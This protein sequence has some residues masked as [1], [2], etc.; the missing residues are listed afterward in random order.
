MRLVPVDYDPFAETAPEKTAPAPAPANV[1]L[2]PVD[3]DPFSPEFEMSRGESAVN[4]LMQGATHTLASV[5]KAVGE[6]AVALANLFGDNPVLGNPEGEVPEDTWT[7]QLGEQLSQWAKDNFPT[8]PNFADDFWTTK[9]PEGV[10]STVAFAAGGLAGKAAKVPVLATSGGM[11]AAAEGV[12]GVE[13]YKQHQLKEGK[14]VDPTERAKVFSASLP[15]GMT[16]AVPI[17]RALDRLDKV[18]GG[19]VKKIAAEGLKGGVEELAQ[20]VVQRIGGNLVAGK[21]VAYDPERGVF[22]GT[23]EAGEVGFTVG[24]LLNTLTAS[25]GLRR[26][27]AATQQTERMSEVVTLKPVEGDPFAQDQNTAQSPVDMPATL[28]KGHE[29]KPVVAQPEKGL[30]ESQPYDVVVPALPVSN[31]SGADIHRIEPVQKTPETENAVVKRGED[32][33]DEMKKAAMFSKPKPVAAAADAWTTLSQGEAAFQQPRSEAKELREITAEIDPGIKVENLNVPMNKRASQARE[34]KLTMPDG[35]AAYLRENRDGTLELNAALLK[36]GQSRGTALY[37]AVATFAHNNG[38]VFMGD[39]EGLS[40][41]A[42]YRRTEHMLSSALKFGTTRHLLPHPSQKVDWIKGDDKGNL[43][44]LIQKHYANITEQ[45]PLIKDIVYDFG[46]KVFLLKDSEGRGADQVVTESDF[47]QLSDSAGARA[48]KAGPA[49]LKR[50]ALTNTFLQ[51]QSPE[52]RRQVLAELARQLHS[53]L[54]PDLKNILY[55]K[56]PRDAGLSTSEAPETYKAPASVKK[57]LPVEG[58]KRL[59]AQVQLKWSDNAPR[60]EVVQS[61]DDVPPHLTDGDPHNE[62]VIDLSDFTIYLVA[63]NLASPQRVMEVLAHEAVGHASMEQM[64]GDQFEAV[65]N[66]VH[67]LKDAGQKQVS[68][69]A[70]EVAERYGKLGREAEAKE[71]IAVMAEQGIKHPVID[72]VITAIKNFL[73]KLGI[74]LK[75]SERELRALVAKAEARLKT[76]G[77]TATRKTD[78][79]TGKGMFSKPVEETLQNIDEVVAEQPA[80]KEI[81]DSVA[82]KF[83]DARPTWLGALTRLQLAD[84]GGDVLPQMN[85]YVKRAQQMDAE[86]NHLIVEAADIAKPWAEWSRANKGQAMGLSELMHEATLAGVD[87]SVPYEPLI[88]KQDAQA[89]IKT[90]SQRARLSSGEGGKYV[91]LANEVRQR[92]A[93]EQ[94]RVVA[95]PELKKKWDALPK[96]AKAI[97]E[98]VRDLYQQRF[99]Q[100]EQALLDRIDRAELSQS[101]KRKMKDEIRLRFESARVNAPYFPLARFGDFWVSVKKDGNWQKDFVVRKTGD[102]F[103]VFRKNGRTALATFAKRETAIEYA[104]EQV[105]ESEFY[106]FEGSH[107]QKAFAEQKRKQGFAITT[108]KKLENIKAV[109][110]AGAGFVSDVIG[111]LDQVPG[112]QSDMVKDAVYQLYLS[113]LPELSVRKHFIHRKKTEGYNE[114]AMRAFADQTFHGAYQLAKLQHADVLEAMLENMREQVKDSS[115]ANKASDILNELQKRHEWAMNPQGHPAANIATQGAFIWYLGLT[116]SAAL[117]NTSQTALVAAPVMAA[118]YGWGKTSKALTTAARDFFS[119]RVGF[120]DGLFSAEK[121]ANITADEKRAFAQWIDEGVIDKTLAHDLAQQ[122]EKPSEIYSGKWSKVMNVIS[123]GFHHAER[124][125]REVTAL[126]AY[127][128][129]RNNNM[130]HAQAVDEARRITYESHFDYSSA[131]KAR[132]MQNDAAKVVLIFRQYSLNMTYLLARNL[133]QGVKGES[134]E[135]RQ[136][137]RRKLAGVLGMHA[138]AAGV[139]GLPMFWLVEFILNSIFD[140]ENEPWDFRTEFRNFLADY[141]GDKGAEAI[142]VGPVQALT[143]V[144]LHNRVSL[145]ELWIRSPGRDLEMQQSIE[146]YMLQLGFGPLGSIFTGMGRG[147]DLMQRGEVGRGIEAMTPKAIRDGLKMMRYASEGVQNLRGDQVVDDLNA[148][149]LFLQGIGFTPANVAKQYDANRALKNYQNRINDRRQLLMNRWWLALQAGDADGVADALDDIRNFNGKN[150]TRRI[151]FKTLKRSALTRRKRNGQNDH[152]VYLPKRDRHLQGRVRFGDE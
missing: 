93:Q 97:Y 92:L 62:A 45:V 137:A 49:T 73:R 7:F 139:T 48:A 18:T 36:S 74:N 138:M 27:R 121:S 95:Y 110:G 118:E 108:G 15:V 103:G 68:Q 25:I 125:N 144:G 69:I 85:T 37:N 43:E 38:K 72:R 12:G 77:K 31:E 99:D 59:V 6:G 3:Y 21:V 84:V 122:S 133:Q 94:N 146:Y 55:S 54:D 109:H 60:I 63:D 70:N 151:D 134:A 24:A 75:Y 116:P 81:K 100:T 117:V 126:A 140:D 66:R 148:W 46:E 47:Q 96:E 19:G 129:A 130:S 143:G 131:N 141:F 16:E 8:N 2:E 34:W 120:K 9:V 82:D 10:G 107:Q 1:R 52:G 89:Q 98:Q 147:M 13:E 39:R 86:R 115:D 83:D 136:M 119:G 105:Q 71:I 67:Q 58:V 102:E 41:E 76:G 145:N 20:E 91:E 142:T 11:G 4:S 80:W 14:P 64:L 44:R 111:I 30:E 127:R 29:E 128:L 56:K 152:G 61:I 28:T 35:K 23:R 135:V 26:G 53:E 106:M 90:L 42:I 22:E 78:T 87:P 88:T 51:E 113:T 33:A 149:E 40:P 104:Q 17:T 50:A 112:S 79:A 32:I 124:F 5:P 123:F 57:G 150:P 114:D 101:E 132:F 65:I